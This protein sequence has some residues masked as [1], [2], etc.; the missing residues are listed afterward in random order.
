M[1]IILFLS[2]YCSQQLN[3]KKIFLFLTDCGTNPKLQ[4]DSPVFNEN[5]YIQNSTSVSSVI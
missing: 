1:K 4:L 2:N 3:C 5:L